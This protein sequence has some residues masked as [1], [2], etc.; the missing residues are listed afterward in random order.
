MLRFDSVSINLTQVLFSVII[1]VVEL[2]TLTYHEI[3]SVR[4]FVI[5][6]LC[7][8]PSLSLGIAVLSCEIIRAISSACQGEASLFLYHIS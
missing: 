5:R 3:R 1:S 8:N 6:S 4:L 2:S 7:M